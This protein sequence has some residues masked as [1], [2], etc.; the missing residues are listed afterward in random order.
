MLGGSITF[1]DNREILVNEILMKFKQREYKEG[2]DSN[3]EFF[4]S[5]KHIY[6]SIPQIEGSDVFSIIR[7]L[8]KGNIFIYMI[9]F[10]VSNGSVMMCSSPTRLFLATVTTYE[11]KCDVD[12]EQELLFICTI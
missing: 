9:L 8:P 7:L 2:L 3:G 1:S 11:Y 5:S 6:H 12:I 10:T 4:A